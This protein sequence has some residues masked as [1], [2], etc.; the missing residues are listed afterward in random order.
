ML[1]LAGSLLSRPE[2]SSYRVG[3]DNLGPTPG[4]LKMVFWIFG[5]AHFL[6]GLLWKSGVQNDSF[7]GEPNLVKRLHGV[8]FIQC[9]IS[10][11]F[12]I[13]LDGT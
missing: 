4:Y 1:Q 7:F 6:G 8:V 2:F 3:I 11:P 12:W 5:R 10:N 13:C 9:W